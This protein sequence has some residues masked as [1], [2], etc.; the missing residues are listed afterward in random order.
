MSA[1]KDWV[2]ENANTLNSRRLTKHPDGTVT[3]GFINTKENIG[4][5]PNNVQSCLPSIGSGGVLGSPGI[6]PQTTGLV[7]TFG[8]TVPLTVDQRLIELKKKIAEYRTMLN[9]ATDAA[10]KRLVDLFLVNIE[11][12]LG[13]I[14]TEFNKIPKQQ[15]PFTTPPF[16]PS[17]PSPPFIPG[18]P[19][20]P[21]IGDNIM[22][23]STKT[24]L[25]YDSSSVSSVFKRTPEMT[26]ALRKGVEI[27]P[28]MTVAIN[29]EAYL[30]NNNEENQ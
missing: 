6:F 18:S 29:S 23:D 22:Y 12:E 17:Y 4:I 26:E 5:A 3:G 10:T 19:L 1:A 13:E 7:T 16:Q 11:K 20:F 25:S 24:G 27:A 28:G 2:G 8:L 30:M 9:V 21:G 14:Q 15:A